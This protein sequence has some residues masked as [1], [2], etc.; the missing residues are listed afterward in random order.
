MAKGTISRETE[1]TICVWFSL[2]VV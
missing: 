2:V 1:D